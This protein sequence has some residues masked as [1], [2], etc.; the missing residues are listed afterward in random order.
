[1]LPPVQRMEAYAATIT[2][3]DY[4]YNSAVISVEAGTDVSAAAKV[5]GDFFCFSEK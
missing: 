2:G 1:M 4:Y 5:V 3:K